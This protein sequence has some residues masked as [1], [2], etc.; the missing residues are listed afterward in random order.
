MIQETEIQLRH[1]KSLSG[2]GV[3]PEQFQV[4]LCG[5]DV[6]GDDLLAVGDR[7]IKRFSAEGALVQRIPTRD[8]DWCVAAAANGMWV[9]MQG[10]LELLDEQGTVIETL[11]DSAKLGRITSLACYEDLIFAA[12]A[13]NSTIHLFRKGVWQREVGRDANTRGFMIPN[14]VL[15]LVI[16]PRREILLVA[17]SQKHRVERYDLDGKYIDSF[18][19][20]GSDDPA[21]F[22]GCCNPTNVTVIGDDIIAVSV[23]APPGIKLYTSSGEFFV[24]TIGPPIDANTKNIDL[25]ADGR[26][27]LFAT[28]PL[29]C[30]I[31]VFKVQSS[32]V[33]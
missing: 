22:G 11:S 2:K 25:V 18:G 3:R 6:S 14:G 16:D 32:G 29:R 27:R 9:G 7:E 30:A 1:Q 10:A 12:D 31:E 8:A 26:G 23:K 33:G 19:R 4:R 5:I 21:V 24:Q 28:D 17:H 20:F 13:T 15:D